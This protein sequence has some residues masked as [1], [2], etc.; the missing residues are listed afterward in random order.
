MTPGARRIKEIHDRIAETG[1]ICVFAEPQFESKYVETVM[2]GTKARAAVLDGLGAAEASG[3]Q[4]YAAMMR[5]FAT[6]LVSCLQG[7]PG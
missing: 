1:A 7:P 3:S 2:E 5:K 4:A 6:A